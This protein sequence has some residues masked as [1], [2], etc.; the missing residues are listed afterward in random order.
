L[1]YLHPVSATVEDQVSNCT[2][3]AHIDP[4]I[5]WQRN[6]FLLFLLFFRVDGVGLEAVVVVVEEFITTKI[7]VI[8]T[9]D[10]WGRHEC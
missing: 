10:Y 8:D 7:V 9:V 6:L 2:Y 3:D 1:A 4:W 5:V